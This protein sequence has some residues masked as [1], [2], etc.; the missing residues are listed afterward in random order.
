MAQLRP[1][2]PALDYVSVILRGK[3]VGR[4]VPDDNH[5]LRHC[6]KV[7][8]MGYPIRVVSG[9]MERERE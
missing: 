4:F 6:S 8:P 5:L 9:T 1:M 3:G 2:T 7:Y